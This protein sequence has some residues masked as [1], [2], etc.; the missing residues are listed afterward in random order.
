MGRPKTKNKYTFARHVNEDWDFYETVNT[1]YDHVDKWCDDFLSYHRGTRRH[2][3]IV[4]ATTSFDGNYPPFGDAIEAMAAVA[5][6]ASIYNLMWNGQEDGPH[7]ASK[8]C[9]VKH[10]NDRLTA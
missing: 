9:V 2:D 5:G 3:I 8:W 6:G 4:K 10:V 7:S 1:A